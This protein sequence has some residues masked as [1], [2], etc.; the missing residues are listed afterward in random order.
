[1]DQKPADF[2][3]WD[4]QQKEWNQLDPMNFVLP[5]P[6]FVIFDH[7][8]GNLFVMHAIED[9]CAHSLSLTG[10][11]IH[12]RFGYFSWLYF[13]CNYI[14]FRKANSQEITAFTSNIIP[15]KLSHQHFWFFFVSSSIN[16][17]NFT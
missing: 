7:L 9:A 12:G 13:D 15:I 4:E 8:D 17:I 2:R 14:L 10:A 3:Q 5:K 16:S 6:L 11:C 1:M